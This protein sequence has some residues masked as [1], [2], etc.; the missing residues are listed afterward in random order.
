MTNLSVIDKR[1]FYRSRK[2]KKKKKKKKSNQEKIRSNISET[3][4][5]KR[6]INQK[7]KNV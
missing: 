2:S 7:S 5:G 3:T 4:R 1:W 6:N